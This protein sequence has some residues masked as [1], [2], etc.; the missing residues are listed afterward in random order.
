MATF[1]AIR[2]STIGTAAGIGMAAM[3]ALSSA[4]DARAEDMPTHPGVT[5]V[6][7]DNIPADVGMFIPNVVG[8]GVSAVGSGVVNAFNDPIGHAGETWKA[9]WAP[10]PYKVV[11]LVP[12]SNVVADQSVVPGEDEPVVIKADLRP[13]KVRPHRLHRR[14]AALRPA[15]AAAAPALVFPADDLAEAQTIRDEQAMRHDAQVTLLDAVTRANAAAREQL[16][17]GAQIQADQAAK[18]AAQGA[19]ITA[20]DATI[21]RVTAERD[22]AVNSWHWGEIIPAFIA[23]AAAALASAA[24]FL[25][26]AFLRRRKQAPAPQ[27]QVVAGDNPPPPDA[28]P[29]LEPVM[30]PKGPTPRPGFNPNLLGINGPEAVDPAKA[31]TSEAVIEASSLTDG[32]KAGLK[33]VVNETNKQV[34]SN[35]PPISVEP[36]IN[37]G[38][39]RLQIAGQ[40]PRVTIR[41]GQIEI[42]SGA[43]QYDITAVANY[44]NVVGQLNRGN[45]RISVAGDP[46]VQ[47]ALR[48][49][50]LRH[51]RNE[52]KANSQGT[53]VFVPY[54]VNVKTTGTFDPSGMTVSNPNFSGQYPVAPV[55]EPPVND[56]RAAALAV[57]PETPVELAEAADAKVKGSTPEKLDPRHDA[58]LEELKAIL[59]GAS[60]V[61][62]PSGPSAS[63]VAK[64]TT[65][66]ELEMAKLNAVAANPLDEKQAETPAKSAS[67]ENPLL[68]LARDFIAATDAGK[69][70]EASQIGKAI[71]NAMKAGD[72]SDP[73]F[74]AQAE[75]ALHLVREYKAIAMVDAMIA[76]EVTAPKAAELKATMDKIIAAGYR[77]PRDQAA[78]VLV[79]AWDKK[80]AAAQNSAVGPVVQYPTAFKPTEDDRLNA[81]EHDATG[82]MINLPYVPAG[83]AFPT[84]AKAAGGETLR[85]GRS[86]EPAE[87]LALV[88]THEAPIDTSTPRALAESILVKAWGGKPELQPTGIIASNAGASAVRAEVRK[89]VFVGTD[90]QAKTFTQEHSTAFYVGTTWSHINKKLGL[91]EGYERNSFANPEGDRSVYFVPASKISTEKPWNDVKKENAAFLVHPGHVDLIDQAKLDD[92]IK[93]M[94][95]VYQGKFSVQAEPAYLAVVKE[96]VQRLLDNDSLFTRKSG[97]YDMP[98][99]TM[100]ILFNGEKL[101]KAEPNAPGQVV[102]TAAAPALTK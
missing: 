44:I 47:A 34:S 37:P 41:K 56:T 36:G 38:D 13:T 64:A 58:M 72:K 91:S 63:D 97:Q 87:K 74:V 93:M 16:A 80:A 35:H 30:D 67:T 94:A 4:K 95:Y 62:K 49:E 76:A 66:I 69:T 54:G 51:R 8:G 68:A 6:V 3:A 26:P 101:T 99:K 21:N 78:A 43:N 15:A 53:P 82:I 77:T 25:V 33:F 96:A 22:T 88:T 57:T 11:N 1:G 83:E 98:M 40:E 52:A 10:Y 73:A 19:T 27:R 102:A 20:Q 100:E 9:V 79:E 14:P 65:A 89:T 7:T 90:P 86:P 81:I 46:T 70:D 71:V 59:A 55:S 29:S 75:R 45:A 84:A 28:D 60:L 50:Q 31:I 32:E 2:K 61:E 18:I 12:D 5:R 24:A 17:N 23:G 42:A 48:K 85:I 92:V 39:V